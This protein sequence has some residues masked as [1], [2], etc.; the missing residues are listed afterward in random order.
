MSVLRELECPACGKKTYHEYVPCLTIEDSYWICR[1]CMQL[2]RE[3]Q[4][5]DSRDTSY[6]KTFKYTDYSRI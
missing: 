2:A 6:G 1:L 4:K 5:N 3:K